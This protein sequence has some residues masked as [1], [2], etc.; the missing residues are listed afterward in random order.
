MS[1][2]VYQMYKQ[3]KKLI[4]RSLECEK[5]CEHTDEPLFKEW[6]NTVEI[7]ELANPDYRLR[8][9]SECGI[10]PEIEEIAF[11]ELKSQIVKLMFDFTDKYAGPDSPLYPKAAYIMVDAITACLGEAQYQVTRYHP[12]TARQIDHICYQIGDWYIHMKSLLEGQQHNLGSQKEV[13]KNMI[14]GEE[15]GR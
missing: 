7:L 5:G 11:M 1:D 15:P 9:E 2:L 14:C 10:R 6:E 3:T 13:L 8:Y 4:K 12:F